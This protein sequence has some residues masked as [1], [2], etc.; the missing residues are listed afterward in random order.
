MRKLLHV[1]TIIFLLLFLL[2]LG[3]CAQENGNE[4]D[5][6]VWSTG[7][8]SI[9][10]QTAFGMENIDSS[11]EVCDSLIAECHFLVASF[12]PS[13]GNSDGFSSE[14][15]I[16]VEQSYIT[17][18]YAYDAFTDRSALCDAFVIEWR[19]NL[20]SIMRLYNSSG[21]AVF[22]AYYD[23]WG[24][25]TVTTNTIGFNRGYCGHEMLNDLQLINMNGRMYDPYVARFLS[26]DNYVQMPTSAQSFNRYSYCLNNPLKYVDA[27]GEL[28]W[29]VAGAAIGGIMN[30]A[31]NSDHI[32]NIGDFAKYFGAG[33]LAGAAGGYAGGFVAGAIGIGGAIG[34]AA[35][36]L[37]GGV[38]SGGI[39][40]GE[41]ALLNGTD[42]WQGIGY[43]SLYGGAIGGVGGFVIGGITSALQGN[44]FWTGAEPTIVKPD[45]KWDP[46]VIPE[47][48]RETHNYGPQWQELLNQQN[49]YYRFPFSFDK[50]IV[51]EGQLFKMENGGAIFI[52]PGSI[53]GTSG[54]YTIGINY[55]TG[56]IYHRC[57]YELSK[58][59]K[60]FH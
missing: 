21:T 12:L 41:N 28:W 16:A 48:M 47:S 54:F 58:F 13:E 25:Q 42:F 38:V 57:F 30:L 11:V 22:S 15:M 9:E 49:L 7:P 8:R 55:S 4:A 34:G 59:F 33:A 39:L 52:A 2:P 1:R 17:L 3:L 23:P 53:N 24:V 45:V 56:H 43:G 50:Q 37:A 51:N 40:G 36:G 60:Q 44:N 29:L 18:Q 27:D 26:P 32:H 31:T 35:S 14:D 6:L 19:K 10:E 46:N 20:G 5:S